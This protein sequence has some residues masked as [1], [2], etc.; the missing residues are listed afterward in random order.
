MPPGD[1][2]LPGSLVPGNGNVRPTVNTATGPGGNYQTQTPISPADNS[3]SYD[4]PQSRYGPRGGLANNGMEG[5]QASDGRA[6]RG[7]D[8]SYAPMDSQNPRDR[9][10]NSDRSAPRERSRP[11]GRSHTKSPAS[12]P[13][14][15]QKCGEHLTG[16]FVR[17]LGATFHLECFRCEVRTSRVARLCP[18]SRIVLTGSNLGLRSN[19]RVKIL[20]GRRGGWERAVSTV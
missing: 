14:V 19:R 4:S 2:S 17:A 13:R 15:C 7:S 6:G 9:V 10:T 18:P 8:H 20:P 16:Q 3:P 11:N 1:G 5:G 12:T